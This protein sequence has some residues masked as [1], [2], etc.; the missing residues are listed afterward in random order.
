MMTKIK[1]KAE[2]TGADGHERVETAPIRI[3]RDLNNLDGTSAKV[4]QDAKNPLILYVKVTPPDGIWLGG[5]FDFRLNF[6]DAYP[7]EPPKAT[8][9]GPNRLWHPNI[10][11][12]AH[13]AEWGVCLNI[14]RKDWK[15]VLGVRD[16]L[17]GLEMMFFEPNLEDP[18]PGTAKDA[19]Q[20]MHDNKSAFMKKAAAWMKG[21]YIS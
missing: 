8:Y 7:H 11:G 18:L 6:P 19:A 17:F 15:P 21:N 3:E 13:L 2:V 20:Q 9:L 12:D 10:E 1:K 16:I 14:L 5:S 4:T